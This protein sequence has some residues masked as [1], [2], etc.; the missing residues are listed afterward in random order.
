MLPNFHFTHLFPYHSTLSSTLGDIGDNWEKRTSIVIYRAKEPSINTSTNSDGSSKQLITEWDK[1]TLTYPDGTAHNSEAFFL[2]P[3]NELFYI[4]RKES[5]KMWRTPIKWGSDDASMTL[6]RDVDI[7]SNPNQVIVGADMSADG[8]ELLLKYYG[9]VRYYCRQPGESMAEILSTAEPVEL[10]YSREPR[11][12]AVA[13]AA[14]RA[15]GYYTLS[16]N[17][18]DNQDQPLYHYARVP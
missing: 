16:E 10:P 17:N 3:T 5:G 9:T 8:R 13:F 14:S 6:V 18:G 11:G 12:E 1:L 4:I 15:E 7:N 2:D